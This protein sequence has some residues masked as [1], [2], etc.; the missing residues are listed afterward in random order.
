MF[1][2]R[3]ESRLSRLFQNLKHS[4]QRKEAFSLRLYGAGP[5]KLTYLKEAPSDRNG[6]IA[7][8]N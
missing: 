1:D 2:V 8:L 3:V 7:L 4:F 6:Q 5:Q